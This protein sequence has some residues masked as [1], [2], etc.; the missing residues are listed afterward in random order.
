M[1]TAEVSQAAEKEVSNA[2]PGVVRPN[3]QA[4]AA[5]AKPAEPSGARLAPFR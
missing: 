5:D 3:T 2:L 1:P 4:T